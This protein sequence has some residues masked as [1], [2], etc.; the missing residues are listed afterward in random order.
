MC[1]HKTKI[2]NLIDWVI[3]SMWGGP[4]VEWQALSGGAFRGILL[5]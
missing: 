5:M 4:L 3:R 1:L 2:E